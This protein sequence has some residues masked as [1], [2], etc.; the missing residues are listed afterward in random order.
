MRELYLTNR[1][2]KDLKRIKKRNIDIE[3]LKKVIEMLLMDEKLPEQYRDHGLSGEYIGVR[4]CHI[5]PDWL[6]L[7]E[8]SG[9]KLVLIL[10]RT[11]SHS[12]IFCT[13]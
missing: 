11:G 7:Y 8:L 10:N 13:I 12:D 4:E 6:L 3:P 1:F 5:R 9:D 2:E